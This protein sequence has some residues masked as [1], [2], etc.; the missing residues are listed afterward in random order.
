V[1][2]SEQLKSTNVVWVTGSGTGIGRA[3]SLSFAQLGCPVVVSSRTSSEVRR[4]AREIEAAGGRAIY[5]TCDVSSERSVAGAVLRV[6]KEFGRIDV[7]VNNAGAA[8]FKPIVKTTTEEFDEIIR[9]NLRGM[10]L[11]TRA[12]L[13]GMIKRRRGWIFNIL[14]VAASTPFANNAAYCAAKAGGLMFTAVLRKEVSGY[15]IRVVA[16]LPGATETSIWSKK[17]R[18]KYG[19]RMMRPEDIAETIIGVYN[20]PLRMLTEQ[21]IIRPAAGDL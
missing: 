6:V 2:D 4:V 17:V 10:F 18:R 7:L 13:K 11:C 5:L 15:G 1:R 21:I 19:H 16:V 9:S 3:V 20:Q 14:S 12:V 8:Y